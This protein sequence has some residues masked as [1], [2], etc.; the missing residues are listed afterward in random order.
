MTTISRR[1]FLIKLGLSSTALIAGGVPVLSSN[2][3]SSG[4]PNKERPPFQFLSEP[5]LQGLT[6]NEVTI[7]CTTNNKAFTWV[8]FGENDLK[9]RAVTVKY[10]LIESNNTV[11]KIT[12]RNLKP[13]TTYK[14]KVYSQEILSFNPDTLDLGSSAVSKEYT[15]TTVD[16]KADKVS[17]LMLNDVHDRPETITHLLKLYDPLSTDF[18]LMNGDIFVYETHEQQ[19]F[20][21]LFIPAT[22]SF[23]S[24]VPLILNRGNHECRGSFARQ[25]FDYVHYPHNN[26]KP[27]YTF[28]LGPVFWIVLDSGEDKPDDVKDYSGLVSFDAFREEQA[29]W[30]KEEV[31]KDKEYKKAPFRVVLVHMPPFHHNNWHGVTHLKNLFGPMFNKHKVDLLLSGHT[32]RHGIWKPE[33]DHNYPIV[34]G[35]GNRDGTRTITK[36]EADNRK[37][38]ISMKLD[39]GSTLY[40]FS[41]NK[42]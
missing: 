39:D 40:D 9:T 12:I 28:K 4:K 29:K 42:R 30:F 7:C 8:A 35:G 34:L 14:Y 26:E 11:N 13:A 20:N 21:N 32:H 41:I 31:V 15:F 16:P 6:E 38:M 2:K 5:Y 23:A 19:L 17:M 1:N 10:G 33:D 25:L 18:V 37:I 27:Y 24:Q 22:K 3:P 36:L